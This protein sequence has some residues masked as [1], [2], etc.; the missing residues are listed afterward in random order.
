MPVRPTARIPDEQEE[1]ES[2]PNPDPTVRTLQQ[3]QREISAAREI[4][5]ARFEGHKDV[6]DTRLGAMDKAVQ[7]LQ[8]HA[9]TLPEQAK[10]EVAHLRLLQDERF[11]SFTT[12]L[13]MIGSRTEQTKADAEKGIAAAL[14]AQKEAAF[15]QSKNFKE[16]IQSITTNLDTLRGTYMD[17]TNDVKEL[18][19]TVENSIKD[20]LRSF[21][22]RISS[23]EGQ[24]RGGN[25]AV[26]IMLSLGA[27]AVAAVSAAIALYANRIH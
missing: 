19:R 17:K 14:Q 21:E 12:Q 9:N 1:R 20:I 22:T 6:I 11:S 16:Q 27:I 15:E 4:L 10:A 24:K 2:K 23:M 3:S 8:V 25:D 7:L 18:V 5:E 26:G 13:I